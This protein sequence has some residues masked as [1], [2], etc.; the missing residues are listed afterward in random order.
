M[1]EV[2]AVPI[3]C[4]PQ[5]LSEYLLAQETRYVQ[6]SFSPRASL[7]PGV[8]F[9]YWNVYRD[10]GRR[11]QHIRGSLEI[12]I[13]KGLDHFKKWYLTLDQSSVRFILEHPTLLAS[14][15]S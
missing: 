12:A 1:H 4:S 2:L 11:P 13:E 7:Q 8:L 15:D 6:S 10:V 3:N 14:S 9:L 5:L